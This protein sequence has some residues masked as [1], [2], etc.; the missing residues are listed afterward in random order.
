MDD[1]VGYC[2]VVGVVDLFLGRGGDDG[3]HRFGGTC[4]EDLQLRRGWKTSQR[5]EFCKMN[6]SGVLLSLQR[7]SG[8]RVG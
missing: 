5:L 1:C 6:L 7:Q 8:G 4:V 2:G 3:L